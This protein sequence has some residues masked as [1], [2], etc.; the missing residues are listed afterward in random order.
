MANI[1]RVISR[2][3]YY[4]HGAII[5]ARYLLSSSLGSRY[6]LSIQ[7]LMI[8]AAVAIPESRAHNAKCLVVVA[9]RRARAIL[10]II[11]GDKYRINLMPQPPP[12]NLL[13]I[14]SIFAH[15]NKKPEA[16]QRGGQEL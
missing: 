15:N 6:I 8:N 5:K 16:Q 1:Q 14:L 2:I 7:H 4:H 9:E 3:N 10:V 12:T 11:M 13:H